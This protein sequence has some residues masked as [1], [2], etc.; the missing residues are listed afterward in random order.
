MDGAETKGVDLELS[1]EVLPGWNVFTGYSHSRTEDADGNRLTT[2]LPMDTFRLWNTYRLQG[3]WDKLT[4][5]G[6]VNWNSKSTLQYARYNSHVTQDDYFVTSL[7]ARYRINQNL[8]ATLNVNNVFDKKYYAG[9][10]G[11]YGHYGAPR[12]ATVSLR[13]DF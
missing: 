1:G 11:S 9:M 8:A 5:G 12:N 3:D 2:Q 4:L 10:A 6:G 13:Y 7:M